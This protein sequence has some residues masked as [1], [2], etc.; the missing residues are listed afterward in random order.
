MSTIKLRNR[1]TGTVVDMS[2]SHYEGVLKE[3]GYY[4]PVEGIS[5][6]NKSKTKSKTTKQKVD[7]KDE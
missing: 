4:I 7:K 6:T 3:Q 2:V 1:K 5:Q